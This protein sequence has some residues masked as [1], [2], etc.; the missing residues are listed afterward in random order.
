MHGNGRPDSY[1]SII[2]IM[3]TVKSSR[4]LKKSLLI[5]VDL[6]SEGIT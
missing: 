4:I 2:L 3:E 6:H 1:K 5:N